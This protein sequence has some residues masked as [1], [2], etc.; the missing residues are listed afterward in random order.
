MPPAF[1]QALATPQYG[2]F[3]NLGSAIAVE[4]LAHSGFGFLIIDGEHAPL[5]LPLVHAQLMAMA[6]SPTA[7][8][9]R[10]PSN[11]IVAIKQ[12]L[13][14][15]PDGLMVPMID[16]ADQAREAVRHARYPRAGVRGIHS[17]TRATRYGRDKTYVANAHERFVL[18][19]QIE[20][21]TGLANL[22]SICAVDGVDAIFFGPADYSANA[23]LI[24]Q[25]RHPDVQ[26]AMEDGVR[27]VRAC[28]RF[29]GLMTHESA[30]PRFVEAGATLLAVG[31]D[32]GLLVTGA[33]GLAQRL[34]GKQGDKP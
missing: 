5:S 18:I 2:L 14:L 19:L 9:V 21:P 10:V 7:A 6:A 12:C 3:C 32:T 4:A 13:D 25:P 33:D 23:G 16:T 15:G 22:E 30:A 29:A 26:D 11:D 1:R 27:R 24:G 17:V 31:M 8:V 20:S 34:N 28:G